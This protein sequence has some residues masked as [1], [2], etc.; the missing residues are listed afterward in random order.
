MCYQRHRPADENRTGSETT[1]FLSE[2][3]SVDTNTHNWPSSSNNSH[4]SGFSVDA[5][6][7][8][9][10]FAEIATDPFYCIDNFDD[11]SCLS[12]DCD[13]SEFRPFS[14]DFIT[15]VLSRIRPTSPGPEAI[16]FWFYRSCAPEL[17]PV[18]AKLINFSIQQRTVPLAWKTAY[19]TPIKVSHVA[20]PGDFRPISVTSI[21]ARTVEKLIVK[22]YLTTYLTGS[23]FN[24]QYAYKP[25]GS[26]TCALVDFT[27]EYIHCLS[28]ISM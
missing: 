6:V 27:Y 1:D 25:T 7:L 13:M 2:G 3:K 19:I 22:N 23:I 12:G 14:A 20:G 8:N 10:F 4:C 24:D 16:P 21:L 15:I 11:A 17:G 18:V 5:S 28:L 26:T 9:A